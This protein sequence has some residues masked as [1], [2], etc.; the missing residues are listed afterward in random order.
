M[1]RVLLEQPP[2]DEHGKAGPAIPG[3]FLRV[4]RTLRQEIDRE[5]GYSGDGRFVLFH[6]EPRGQEVMWHDG[7]S[8]GFGHGGWQAFFDEVEP[9]AREHGISVGDDTRTADHVLVVDR[10]AGKAYFADRQ[11]AQELVMREVA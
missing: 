3:A 7:R 8:Y 1:K 4:V 5:L 2:S 11:Q 6:Y 10:V 9:A